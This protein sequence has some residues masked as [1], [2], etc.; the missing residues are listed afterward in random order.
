ME[1]TPGEVPREVTRRG[2]GDGRCGPMGWR[3]QDVGVGEGVRMWEAAL[4]AQEGFLE[5]TDAR[6]GK[7]GRRWPNLVGSSWGGPEGSLVSVLGFPATVDPTSPRP[8]R[9]P[10]EDK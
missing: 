5:L 8:D 1:A 2:K 4:Q 7:V 6:P 10:A 3:A 9:V